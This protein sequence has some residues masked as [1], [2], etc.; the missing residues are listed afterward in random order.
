MGKT[1]EEL[2]SEE[3]NPTQDTVGFADTLE[4]MKKDP[5]I[6]AMRAFPQHGSCNTYDHSVSVAIHAHRLARLLHLRVNERMLARGAML[7]DFYLYNIQESG[8]SAWNHGTKHPA[9]ALSNAEQFYDLSERERDMIYSHMWPLTLTQIP[10]CRESML[11]SA[12]DKYCALRERYLQGWYFLR[13]W[14]R[15]IVG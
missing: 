4:A 5:R 14:K 15:R 3:S 13:H 12:A 9:I 6:M 1:I 8:R 11:I 7:H 10:H 2:R